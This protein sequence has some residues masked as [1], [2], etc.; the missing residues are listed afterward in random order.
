MALPSWL[1]WMVPFALLAL[2][3]LGGVSGCSEG[4]PPDT[5]LSQLGAQVGDARLDDTN[6]D[7]LLDEY[8]SEAYR[9]G[10]Q[11]EQAK[12]QLF[13]TAKAADVGL[14]GPEDGPVEVRRAGGGD[15]ATVTFRFTKKEGIFAVAD[16]S[17]IDVAL[18]KAGADPRPWLIETITLTR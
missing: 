16:F 10:V 7:A 12:Y 8:T 15:T 5:T 14:N 9:T 13:L 11:I 17:S 2:L 18:V 3:G 1:K 6:F 4:V